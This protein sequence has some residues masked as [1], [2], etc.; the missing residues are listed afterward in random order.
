MSNIIFFLVLCLFGVIFA[1]Y[2]NDTAFILYD[3]IYGS[4]VENSADKLGR[5]TILPGP[6]NPEDVAP[7]SMLS[8][9]NKHNKPYLVREIFA[10]EWGIY[11]D[12]F[13]LLI[14]IIW[15][16]LFDIWKMFVLFILTRNNITEEHP[17]NLEQ[18]TTV[19][20]EYWAAK[21]E[22]D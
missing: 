6:A 1:F 14:F 2:L 20:N 15:I 13:I 5:I 4:P 8:A 16:S 9:I 22:Q 3:V 12:I 10:D 18:L 19:R 21:G 7:K 17:K 11:I